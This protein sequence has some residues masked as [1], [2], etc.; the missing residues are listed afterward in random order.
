[1]LSGSSGEQR[2]EREAGGRRKRKERPSGGKRRE[3][4]RAHEEEKKILEA[5][6]Y[7]LVRQKAAA[8]HLS[9]NN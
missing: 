8:L 4:E 5:G 9:S 1:M 2:T 7:R 3:R 6:Y